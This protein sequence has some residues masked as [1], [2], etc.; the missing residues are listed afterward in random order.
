MIPAGTF[1]T[2]ELHDVQESLARLTAL[3]RAVADAIGTLVLPILPGPESQPAL[4]VTF[5]ATLI[6]F[7][8]WN[9]TLT[10]CNSEDV[11]AA[12]A[13]ARA[14]FELL[15]DVAVLIDSPMRIDEMR[16]WE[17]SAKLKHFEA[18]LRAGL[19]SAGTAPAGASHAQKFVDEHGHQIRAMRAARWPAPKSPGKGRHPERW[20]A[21]NLPDV[22]R[23][24]VATIGEDTL[25]AFDQF[26]SYMNW[27][28]HGTSLAFF[29]GTS[30]A[31]FVDVSIFSASN[32]AQL[33]LKAA[34]L[35]VGRVDPTVSGPVTEELVKLYEASVV[36]LEQACSRSAAWRQRQ[37]DSP[38]EEGETP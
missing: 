18:R 15:A 29:R 33:A 10:K 37:G 28:T 6:R 25:G 4:E 38:N 12:V 24:H 13:G 32:A 1:M 16:D 11:Q 26:Q 34:L 20:Y 3:N 21:L 22:I 7:F 9:H 35:V 17:H 36:A 2:E 5:R 31:A 14:C 19:M 8:G 27:L 30:T 23:K